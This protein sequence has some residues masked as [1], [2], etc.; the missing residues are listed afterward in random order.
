MRLAA[1]L[2]LFATAAY[3]ADPPAD[4]PVS[5]HLE[6][7][8]PSPGSGRWLADAEAVKSEQQCQDDHAFRAKAESGGGI[9]LSPYAVVAIVAGAVASGFAIGAGAAC[10]KTPDFCGL[11]KP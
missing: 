4:T 10:S 8:Q 2:T 11:K 3:A 1:L 9:R 5:A 6:P 7:G